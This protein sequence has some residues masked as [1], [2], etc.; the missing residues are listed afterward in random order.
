MTVNSEALHSHLMELDAA[1]Y[2]A[3]QQPWQGKHLWSAFY[4][5]RL[6]QSLHTSANVSLPPLYPPS[7]NRSIGIA[8]T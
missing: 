8:E 1:I 6:P 2:G 7:V 4:Q 5:Y 3:K